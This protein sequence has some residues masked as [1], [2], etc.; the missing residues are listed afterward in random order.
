MALAARSSILN[1]AKDLLALS[2]QRGFTISVCSNGVFLWQSPNPAY[3]KVNIFQDKS[4]FTP[5]I[6]SD[7]AQT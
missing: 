7:L 5:R 6:G 4:K 1:P 3:K 2:S